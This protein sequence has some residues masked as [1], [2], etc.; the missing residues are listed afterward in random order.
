MSAGSGY[1][2]LLKSVMTG[3]GD[4]ELSLSLTRFCDREGSSFAHAHGAH[5]GYL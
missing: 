5:K 4:H 3:D 1:E 2:Y